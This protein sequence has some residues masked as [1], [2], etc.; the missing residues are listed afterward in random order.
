MK[1]TEDR[2]KEKIL[3]NY[4]SV[5]AFAEEIDVPYSTLDTM[6]KNGVENSRFS[7]IARVC[8]GLGIGLSQLQQGKILPDQ[9][10]ASA[11][12]SSAEQ[13]HMIQYRALDRHGRA[14]VDGLLRIEYERVSEQ[15]GY[16]ENLPIAARSKKSGAEQLR[17]R[18]DFDN[19]DLQEGESEF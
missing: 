4:R 3:I 9:R 1:S 19:Q 15:E 11:V 16:L 10:R 18:R 6:L 7:L 17:I 5:R 14:A 8:D 2:L 12:I 13:H